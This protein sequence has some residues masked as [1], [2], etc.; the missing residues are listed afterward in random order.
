[1][2]NPLSLFDI[3]KNNVTKMYKMYKIVKKFKKLE[4]GIIQVIHIEIDEKGGKNDVFQNL[5]TLSTLNWMKLGDYSRQKKE[6]TFC[7]VVIKMTFCRKKMKMI[8]TFE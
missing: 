7:G 4:I 1:M 6:R 8:L 5:S 3:F 2:Q